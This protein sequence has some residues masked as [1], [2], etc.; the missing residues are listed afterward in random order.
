M[1]MSRKTW[2]MCYRGVR[3]HTYSEARKARIA[4]RLTLLHERI[5]AILGGCALAVFFHANKIK[6]ALRRNVREKRYRAHRATQRATQVIKRALSCYGPERMLELLPYVNELAEPKPSAFKTARLTY[7][8][9]AKELE[10]NMMQ[11]IVRDLHPSG[12]TN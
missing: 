3:M 7:E 8:Q 5:G 6:A 4:A 2:L 10:V 1:P 12:P 11:A 9:E